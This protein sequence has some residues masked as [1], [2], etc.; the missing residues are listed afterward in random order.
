MRKAYI[1]SREE[2][3]IDDN[4]IIEGWQRSTGKPTQGVR[5]TCLATMPPKLWHINTMGRLDC[6][7]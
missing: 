7:D 1:R 2:D 5:H 3:I 4:L 6:F